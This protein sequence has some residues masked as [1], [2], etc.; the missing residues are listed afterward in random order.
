MARFYH[1]AD[2]EKEFLGPDHI[3]DH[4]P[5]VEPVCER[6]APPGFICGICGDIFFPPLLPPIEPGGEAIEGNTD[7]CSSC[8]AEECVTLEE[9]IALATDSDDVCIED[10]EDAIDYKAD[11]IAQGRL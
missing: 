8:Y 5:G 3:P 10:I 2:C 6:C 1:C 7:Y 11:L 4:D 9:Q